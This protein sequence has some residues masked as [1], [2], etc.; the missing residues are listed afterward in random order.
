M[1]DLMKQRHEVIAPYPNM[2]EQVGDIL[3]FDG[4][5]G[6]EGELYC[7]Y[8][9][10]RTGMI[11]CSDVLIDL[12]PSIYKGLEWYAHRDI[13]DM[14]EYVYITTKEATS[15]NSTVQKSE[16]WVMEDKPR[17]SVNGGHWYYGNEI[18]PA[19]PEQITTFLNS[20][21]K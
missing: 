14:P 16:L 3:V 20:K 5:H 21:N 11:M 2:T 6:D 17:V 10:E 15:I 8:I 18:L 7:Q 13:A 4:W 1:K 12:F 9:N 19:T